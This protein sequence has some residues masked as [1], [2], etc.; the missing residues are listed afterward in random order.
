MMCEICGYLGGTAF[1]PCFSN[2]R[3]CD[4]C[5]HDMDIIR[6]DEEYERNIT[7]EELGEL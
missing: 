1:Y 7:D 3:L 4:D 6:M 2:R 5:A